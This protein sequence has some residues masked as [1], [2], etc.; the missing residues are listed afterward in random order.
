MPKILAIDDKRDN[1]ISLSALLRNLMP[2]CAVIT[3]QSGHEGIDKAVREAPDVILLDVFMPGMDGFETCR[4]LKAEEKARSIP[5]IMITAIRTDAQSRIKGLEIGADAFLS[6]PIDEQELVS[7]VKVALRIKAAEDALRKERDSLEEIVLARTAEL[8]ESEARFRALHN[9]SFGGITIHDKGVILECNRGL[10]DLTGFSYDELI[11]MNGLL[12]ISEKT[13]DVV[14]RNIQAGYEQPYEAAGVRKNGEEYP[15]RLEA[16]NIPY[17]GKAVRVV[18]FRD[19][20]EHKEAE[21]SLVKAKEQAEAAN[22]AKSE[23]LA[24]MSHELRTPFNGIMGMMQLLQSTPL[25]EEQRE[26]VTLAIKSSER[27]TR[28]L[29]DILDLSSIEA[30]K[31]VICPAQFDL[32]DLLESISGLFVVSARQKGIALEC[33]MDDDVPRHVIG[34]AIRVKQILFNLLGN[35]LKFTERGSV[36]VN[37]ATLSAAKGKD[38]RIMVSISDTG[39]GIPDDKFK[40]LFQPFSQVDG[41]Y[42]RAHQ[43][44][45]LGLVIVRRLV[46]LMGGN[47]DVE[48]VVGQGTTVHVLLPFALPEQEFF[49]SIHATS[50]LGEPKKCLNILLAE[51]EPLNQLFMRSILQKLGHAVTLA[52]NGQEAVEYWKYNEFDC[53]LMDIQMPVVTGVE[54]TKMIRSQESE[55]RSL[56]G[57]ENRMAGFGERFFDPQV[58]GLLPPPSLSPL[59]RHTPIIAVTAH[60]QPG[61]RE[62]FLAAGMDDYLGKP[63]EVKDLEK[64]L[65]RNV[66]KEET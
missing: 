4:G 12:L 63:V 11:G 56:K 54:A 57:A 1:L 50:I 32:G 17:K 48:S 3:A 15:L 31:M 49:E 14:V 35:A 42:T 36:Q 59:S 34:D 53:I 45:G 44:A 66:R 52:Q 27:F 16:R 30:G 5:V 60:T 9:A 33:S 18:E 62:R 61:D 47:I 43:G 21:Q 39:I 13:R 38:A 25:D 58:S 20:T 26:F 23:F 19:I 41:S 64:V 22:L 65:E 24:N 37:L 51:D 7:Q 46:A 6:K 29:S 2:E 55:V 40:D 8:R 10:S 28:L